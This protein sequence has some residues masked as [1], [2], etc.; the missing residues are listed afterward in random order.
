MAPPQ[1]LSP[2]IRKATP[3][4]AQ[5]IAEL[6]SHVFTATFGPNIDPSD[7]KAY[8]LETYS[9]EA[10]AAE[11]QNSQKDMFVATNSSDD[12]MGFALLTQG[13]PYAC[14]AKAP[15]PVQLQR[16][17]LHPSAQG[18]GV[19]K[20]LVQR[21]E[22]EAR[23]QGSE[24]LWLT[25]Y[26]GNLKAIGVYEKLGFRRVGTHDFVTGKKVETDL[27]MLKSL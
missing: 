19:G 26:E 13:P 17:Y 11:I 24:N 3:S 25:V 18:Q 8:L 4:D 27:V 7:L 21:I 5:A 9:I 23:Q 22:A 2:T 10:T 14:I 6:G 12:I 16:I 15:K 20:L 1:S